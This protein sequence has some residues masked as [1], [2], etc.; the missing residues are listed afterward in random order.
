MAT[1]TTGMRQSVMLSL[2][3]LVLGEKCPRGLSLQPK[4]NLFDDV[5]GELLFCSWNRIV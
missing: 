4:S 1:T 2:I 3:D 5:F